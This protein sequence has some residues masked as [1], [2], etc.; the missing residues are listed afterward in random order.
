MPNGTPNSSARGVPSVG[1]AQTVVEGHRH[2][3]H[4]FRIFLKLPAALELPLARD[5]VAYLVDLAGDPGHLLLGRRILAPLARLEP[6]DLGN[7]GRRD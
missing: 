7:I 3:L 2:V 6:D 4:G 1:G 5:A